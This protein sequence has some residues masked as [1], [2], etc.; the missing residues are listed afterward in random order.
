MLEI[1]VYSE[2]DRGK[3]LLSR[4]GQSKISLKREESDNNTKLDNQDKH[5]NN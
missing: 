2:W 5:Y 4:L 3:R 1:T